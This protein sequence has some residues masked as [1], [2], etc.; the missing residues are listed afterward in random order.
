[1]ARTWP[2]FNAFPRILEDTATFL[3]RKRPPLFSIV[4]RKKGVQETIHKI[5]LVQGFWKILFGTWPGERSPSL[6]THFRGLAKKSPFRL[7]VHH[8]LVCASLLPE[9]RLLQ[10]S[11]TDVNETTIVFFLIHRSRDSTL[12]ALRWTEANKISFDLVKRRLS[13][14]S[15]YRSSWRRDS[16]KRSAQT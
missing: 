15:S 11:R 8:D 16:R 9:E 2:C 1:M 7:F 10:L 5:G 12:R 6:W 14:S 13:E 3:C 4:I